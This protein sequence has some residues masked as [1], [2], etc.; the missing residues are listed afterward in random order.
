M[1][2]VPEEPQIVFPAPSNVPVLLKMALEERAKEGVSLEFG[3]VL[4]L[5]E[6][7][8]RQCVADEIT[9]Y[10]N[11]GGAAVDATWRG[12]MLTAQ[13]IALGGD[14][15]G[16]HRSCVQ[17]LAGSSS[18]SDLVAPRWHPGGMRITLRQEDPA[19]RYA[20][21]FVPDNLGR[22]SRVKVYGHEVEATLVDARVIDGG[23]ALEVVV[24]VPDGDFGDQVDL[25]LPGLPKFSVT[26]GV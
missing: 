6:S 26:K 14:L 22:K 19:V 4:A 24:D 12:G 13:R 18:L 7:L 17:Q 21:G 1:T 20:P 23:A 25:L 11:A 9:S 2:T 15:A 8:V 10:L 3:E 5:H 16:L